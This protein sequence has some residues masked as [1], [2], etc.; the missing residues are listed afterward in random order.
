M[1]NIVA[2]LTVTIILLTFA[3]CN[4]DAGNDDVAGTT[5]STH[6]STSS[7]TETTTTTGSTEATA[8]TSSTSSVKTTVSTTSTSAKP[9]ETTTTKTTV[10]T[11]LPQGASST[12]A[13]WEKDDCLKIL[14]IGNSFSDDSM[15]YVYQIA[16]S[17]GVKQVKLGNLYIGGCSLNTHASN[18]KED[19]G[20]YEYRTNTQGSWSTV[21][22]YK[23]SDAIR[24][25]NWDYISLQQ[26]SGSSGREQ[27]YGDLPY[28]ID[29]VRGL[30]PD[31]KIVWNMTW[32]YQ[33]NST[34]SDFNKYQKNQM[35][36]Y[37][38]I[39]AAI[40]KKVAP[41]TAIYTI[42]PT[43]TAIQN[44]RTSYIGDHLTRDGYHLSLDF[45]RYVAGLTFVHKLTGLSIADIDYAPSGVDENKR[46]VAIESATNAVL[47]PT[48]V[49]QSAYSV[50]S[51][52]E[53]Q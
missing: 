19:K 52:G 15:Q 49:T 35:V 51:S 1:K 3:A 34:H 23:M 43:G 13:D 44:A 39:L 36:M 29:Y 20:A 33:Q 30:C 18:A 24:S 16:K 14:T 5:S 28:L 11:T 22:N 7:T 32:A 53:I 25:E 31:A 26:A 48:G 17:V 10:Q 21:P 46:K 8:S 37:N 9:V 45:G 27:T 40:E 42:I 6:N 50:L 2:F 47:S 41:E 12:E 38:A 4:S